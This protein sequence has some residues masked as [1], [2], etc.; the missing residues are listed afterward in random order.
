M[1]ATIRRIGDTN[2][3]VLGSWVMGTTAFFLPFWVPPLRSALGFQT[4][5]YDKKPIL[6][7]R[8]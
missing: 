4:N 2:P 6:R 7:N 8:K 1:W 3:V 5:Q